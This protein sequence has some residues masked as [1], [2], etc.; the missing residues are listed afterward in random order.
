MSDP[1]PNI[2]AIVA[3]LSEAQRRALLDG[4]A[5]YMDPNTTRALRKKGLCESRGSMLTMT[6]LLVRNHLTQ[7]DEL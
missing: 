5:R 7:G 6:G 1:T 3:K 4:L 2:K